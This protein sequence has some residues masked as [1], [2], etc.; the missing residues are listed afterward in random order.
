MKKIL[1]VVDYQNDFVDPKGALPVPDANKIWQNI[2]EKIDS[3]DY[4]ATIY[5]FDTHTPA[6]YNGSDEQKIFPNIHCKYGT[7]GWNFYKIKP[8]YNIEF[9]EAILN[10]DAPFNY[11]KI[12]NEYFFTKDV[13]NIWDG[14]EKYPEW[15]IDTFPKE[16]YEIDVVG[17]A[18]NYCCFL[19]IMGMIKRGYKVNLIQNCTEGIKIF[20][21]KI[22]DISFDKNN[23]IMKD[24][25]VNFI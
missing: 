5:T 9:Q 11:I 10:D 13:F 19:N 3:E 22:I 1:M 21:N 16:E 6:Q 14:N 18:Q 12:N 4:Q 7:E 20:P 17:V 23:K 24:A 15:F 2:Q 8:R 25:G